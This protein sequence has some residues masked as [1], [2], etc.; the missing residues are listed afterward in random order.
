MYG[1]ALLSNAS[2]NIVLLGPHQKY[3]TSVVSAMSTRKTLFSRTN[4]K[5]YGQELRNKRK[6]MLQYFGAYMYMF[7]AVFITVS[8]LLSA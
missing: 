3:G 2:N 5:G 7:I 8:Y 6:C 1:N 4:K